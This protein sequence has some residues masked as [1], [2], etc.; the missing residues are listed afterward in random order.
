M[1]ETPKYYELPYYKTTVS[2]S[3][4]QE[5]I[6]KLLRKYGLQA[7]K[8]VEG[9]NFGK[10]ITV[11]E[12]I[13]IQGNNDIPFQFRFSVNLPENRNLWQQV[14]RSLFYY[15]KARFTR[16]D[17]GINTVEKEFMS[18]LVMK[19]TDG[20]TGTMAE[21]YG[22]KILELRNSDNLLPFKEE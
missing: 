12:F 20:R 9:Y 3:K 16:V 18:E 22:N 5:Q 10:Y 1:N 4:T 14:Y 17:F 7:I 21:L 13:L 2:L 8:F 15:L 19:L 11:I 6:K